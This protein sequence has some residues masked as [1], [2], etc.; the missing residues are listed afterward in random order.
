MKSRLGISVGI[1]GAMIYFSALFG[2]YTVVVLLVGY[3]LLF[4]ESEWLKKSS[5]KATALM[6]FFSFLMSAIGLIPDFLGWINT[7]VSIFNGLFNYAKINSIINLLIQA[8]DI[9]R[10]CLFILLG[11]KALNQQTIAVPFIDKLVDKYI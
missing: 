8:L 2:G 5:V 10:T 4:E 3:V 7:L 9:I 6:V 1:L 11:A